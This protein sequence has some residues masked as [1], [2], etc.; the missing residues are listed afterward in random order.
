MSHIEIDAER[1]KGC[2]LCTQFC[3]KKIIEVSP[4][5]NR[6]GYA[7]A[8]V[9]PEKM[10]ECIGCSACAFTCPDMA[11]KVYRTKKD[12]APTEN[13]VKNVKEENSS[14]QSKEGII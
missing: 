8:Q 14:T 11:I 10:K 9:P 1:C 6:K 12:K 5:F 13:V 7:F 3:P 4:H 2:L